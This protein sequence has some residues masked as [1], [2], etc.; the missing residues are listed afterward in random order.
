[1][2]GF[3]VVARWLH[4]TCSLGLVGL[5][6]ALLLAGRADR[7]T[8]RAWESRMIRGARAL[9]V[10]VL[11]T[12]VAVLAFQAAVVTGRPRAALDLGEWVRLLGRSQFGT[13][14]LVRHGIV[15][16]LAAFLLLR[17]REQSAADRLAFRLEA[18]LL[19]AVAA[20]AMAWAGH[21]A[22]V[23]PGGLTAALLDV[24]HLLAAGAWFGAL[25][26]L[27]LLMRE[28]CADGG[29][30]AR[31]FAVVAV[32][33]FSRLALVVITLVVLT[34]VA[35]TWFQVGGIPAL[36]GTRYGWLLLLKVC[37]LI[38]ILILAQHNRRHLLPRLSDDGDTIGRP[39]MSRLG[40][41]IAAEAGLAL[42]ILLIT[43][44]LSLSPPAVHDTIQWPF[45]LRYSWA[46]AA[47]LPGGASSVLIGGQIA[48]IGLLAV[49]VGL[50]LRS[51]RV[52]LVG[53]GVVGLA[54]GLWI[55]LPPLTVDAY[56]T[57]YRRPSVSYQ[58]VSVASGETLYRAH[59][60]TCHGPG[61]RGDGP[62]GAGLPKPP[63]DLTAAHAAQHTVGDMF[64]WLTHGIPAGGMPP[65]AS[66]LSEEERWDLIN[67]IRTLG[68]GE[69]ARQM[70]ALV[71][72]GRPWLVAP[73]LTIVVGPAPPRT[74]KELRDRWMVLLVLFTLP[75]SRARL[76]QLAESYNSLQ[77]LGAEVIA[78]PLN[79]GA[80][81]IRR[82][83]DQ[84]PMLVPVVTD[85]AADIATTYRLLARGLGTAAAA[86]GGASA[87]HV[88]LLVD[89]QGYI[90]ARWLPG[91][92]GPAWDTMQTLVDQLLLLDKETPAGPAPDEH[93]H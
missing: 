92:P 54:L 45:S 22:A 6:T 93:V 89:R 50:L 15:L 65:F 27:A 64:W 24:V 16:L 58:A 53:G 82:L 18:G 38:P 85:G 68:A 73:D 75:E 29:Q 23:E 83:G 76:V 55:A 7:P 47:S 48:V 61:G 36:V 43:T 69:R 35:N 30:D 91:S 20:A 49:I 41:F 72:P 52:L 34:G 77:A 56:P 59:C 81:I 42:L 3:G 28:A 1:M 14:W 66:L 46:A 62:G 12:G 60:A 80:D 71:P 26:P 8:A 84:P 21:A 11:I 25:A 2:T 79:D 4:L 63:A 19:A 31:P 86:P 88:E 37:L 70:T 90:R 74:L 44:G 78:V 10:L 40:R 39:A 5:V 33:T 9:A 13:V 32:R 17:E 57:T 87:L 51:W 67:F